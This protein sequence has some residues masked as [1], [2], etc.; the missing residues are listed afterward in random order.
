MEE[1]E[2]MIRSAVPGGS[3][4]KPLLLALVALLASGALFRGNDKP[5]TKVS[6]PDTKPDE[7]S[8]GLLGGL[9][10]LIDKFQ[11]SGHGDIINSWLGTGENKPIAPGQVG[12]TLGP[13]I[14]KT[15]A[16]RSGLSEEELVRQLSQVLPGMVDKLTPHGRLPT[17]A[18][19]S[20]SN[21]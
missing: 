3:V 7:G 15:L 10:N 8:G 16:E 1:S 21:R 20:G 14:I 9:G 19:L 12:S 2:N 18:E 5:N 13:N 17:A 11:K 6:V 4:T